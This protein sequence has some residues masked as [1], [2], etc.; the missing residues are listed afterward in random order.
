MDWLTTRMAITRAS[1]D[2]EGERSLLCDGRGTDVNKGKLVLDERTNLLSLEYPAIW[3]QASWLDGQ[4]GRELTLSEVAEGL[5]V[6]ERRARPKLLAAG[7][8]NTAGRNVA[9]VWEFAGGRTPHPYDPFAH[10]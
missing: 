3:H 7:W 2:F 10:P 6:S 9:G 5:G 4:R 1:E 8:Q